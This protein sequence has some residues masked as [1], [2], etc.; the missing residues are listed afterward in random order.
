MKY[1]IVKPKEEKVNEK[2]I[3]GIKRKDPLTV[4]VDSIYDCDI[5]VLQKNWIFDQSCL[6]ERNIQLFHRYKICREWNYF[7]K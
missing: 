3:E 4:I 6:N 1:Y 2:L 7:I 5:V